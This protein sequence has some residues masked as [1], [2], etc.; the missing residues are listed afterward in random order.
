MSSYWWK[1]S[2]ISDYE[3]QIYAKSYCLMS[4]Q[5]KKYSIPS[6]VTFLRVF[7]M[8]GGGSGSTCQRRVCYHTNWSQYRP[9]IGKFMPEDIDASLCTHLIYSFAKLSNDH[10]AAFEWN[11][12]DTAWSTGL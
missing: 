6:L 4:N 5:P 9:G 8:P 10:L 11:D 7:L 2:M 12:E 1:E 3:T